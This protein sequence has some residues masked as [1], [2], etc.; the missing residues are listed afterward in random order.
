MLV[1]ESRQARTDS[2][3]SEHRVLHVMCDRHGMP[4]ILQGMTPL[5]VQPSRPSA[6]Q[7]V[8]SSY[9]ARRRD[10]A[11]EARSAN[12]S[13]TVGYSLRLPANRER[14][15]LRCAE[16]ML[17]VGKDTMPI[18]EALLVDRVGWR[19]RFDLDGRSSCRQRTARSRSTPR[20]PR[21]W[22]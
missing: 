14:F 18:S 3:D 19:Q 17:L 15:G 11:R 13:R 2:T 6:R 4:S 9:S 16:A 21:P 22:C 1:R 12:R 5:L 7:T 20:P 10:T 8:L